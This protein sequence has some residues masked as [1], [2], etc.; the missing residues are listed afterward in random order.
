V[1]PGGAY[2]LDRALIRV[3]LPIPATA[4]FELASVDDPYGLASTA[5]LSLFRRPLPSMNLR[6]LST[7]MFDG[8]ETFKDPTQ[9]SGFATI[10][11]DLLDQANSATLG[12]AQGARPL[13]DAEAVDLR[14]ES[15]P[16]PP[17]SSTGA[18]RLTWMGRGGRIRA[19]PELLRDQRYP[20]R[21]SG[22]EP[23]QR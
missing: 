14:F 3:G 1:G 5:E 22:G 4:E 2:K 16:S 9:P 23:V 20:G 21:R 19:R 15:Q 12:H 7:V 13:T 11:F 18:R 10:D 17:R 8:R 6:F